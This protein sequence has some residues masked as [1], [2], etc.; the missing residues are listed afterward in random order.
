M[1]PG[2]IVLEV[3]YYL[4][5]A[6]LASARG[7]GFTF[8]RRRRGSDCSCKDICAFSCRAPHCLKSTGG[9]VD[10]H[11]G[12]MCVGLALAY[13]LRDTAVIPMNCACCMRKGEATPYIFREAI[14]ATRGVTESLSVTKADL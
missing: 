4:K 11:A 13:K 10:R 14:D 2:D 7:L 1:C 6:P 12:Y 5:Y 8:F 9:R 3:G